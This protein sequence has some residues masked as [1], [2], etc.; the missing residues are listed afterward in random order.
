M[1]LTSFL[2]TK[3]PSSSQWQLKLWEEFK[4]RSTFVTTMKPFMADSESKLQKTQKSQIF[5]F[6]FSKS[7]KH[8]GTKKWLPK[9][10]KHH[11]QCPLL[12][13]IVV[14]T[15]FLALLFFYSLCKLHAQLFL[16]LLLLG[17]IWFT[18][19]DERVKKK[20][21]MDEDSGEHSLVTVGF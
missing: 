10:T 18:H 21:S 6:F 5:F 11:I 3:T 4:P 15:L 7:S 16:V 20:S 1:Q 12:Y 17:L 9:K 2:K 19:D 8:P 14:K 13:S